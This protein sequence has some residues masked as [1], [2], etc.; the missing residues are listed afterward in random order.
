M[1]SPEI[2][3][4]AVPGGPIFFY[5]GLV[6][7][8]GSDDEIAAVLGHESTHIVKRHSAR[9]M[10]DSQGKSV[11]AQIVLGAGRSS[12]DQEQLAGLLIGVQSLKFSRSDEAQADEYGFGY[13]TRAGYNPDAMATFFVKMGQ[14]T[15]GGGPEWLASHPLTGK[16]VEAARRRADDYKKG[17]TKAP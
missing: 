15:G 6:D 3:A 10:S 9:Q 4:F 1:D 2:N 5:K 12:K 7:L 17:T 8:A 11:L 16:R 13:M 14:K